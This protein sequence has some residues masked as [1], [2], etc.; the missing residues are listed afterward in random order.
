MRVSD[1][2]LGVL[3]L[4]LGAAVAVYG[5]G[6]PRMPG[7]AYGAGL[8]PAA[9]GTCL[10]LGGAALAIGGWRRRRAEVL[11]SGSGWSRSPPHLINLLLTFLAVLAFVLFIRSVGFAVLAFLT[12]SV[13]LARFGEPLWRALLVAAI[14]SAAFQYLFVSLMRVPL[15]PGILQ[16]LIY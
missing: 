13:L 3:F 5:I 8:F 11:V 7:Q 10:G 14:T 12:V 6:L 1:G 2:I 16:G 15:P 4:A 9:V